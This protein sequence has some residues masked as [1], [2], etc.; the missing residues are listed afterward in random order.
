MRSLILCVWV[1]CYSPFVFAQNE[2]YRGG[3]AD[4]HGQISQQVVFSNPNS[5]SPFIGGNG[6]GYASDS[7]INFNPHGTAL[8]FSP[9]AGGIGDGYSS[10]SLINAAQYNYITMFSPFKGSNGD[11]YYGDSLMNFGTRDYI[12]MFEPYAGGQADG[13]AGYLVLG[14][15]LPVELLSF[16]GEQVNKQHLLHWTTST[17][18]NTSTFVVERSFSGRDFVS[19]GSIA[20]AGNS[21]TERNYQFTDADPKTGNNFYRLKMIDLDGSF[22]YSNVILLKVL[23]NKATMAVYPNPSTETINIRLDGIEDNSIVNLTLYDIQGKLVDEKNIRKRSASTSINVRN[24]S[25]GI[26]TLRVEWNGEISSFRFIK[27]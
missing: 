1:C 9:F 11:G 21:S 24:L 12:T 25:A 8:L 18:I 10:D 26:Y 16:T 27:Q 23:G 6:D 17:E 7:L 19:L 15:V 5:F 14:V 13:W 2:S 4:G 20:A 22:K 3:V